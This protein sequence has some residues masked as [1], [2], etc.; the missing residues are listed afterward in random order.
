[1]KNKSSKSINTIIDFVTGK[2]IPEIGAEANRQ[3]VERYLVNE[4]G[5]SKK[6]IIVNA[7]INIIIEEDPYLSCLDLVVCVENKTK[8]MAIK[9]AAGSLGSRE[10]EILAGARLIDKKYQVPFAV[11]SDGK[12]ALMLDTVSGKKISEGLNSIFSSKEAKEKLKTLKLQRLPEERI[13]REKLIF[14]TYDVMNVNVNRKIP[15]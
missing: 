14:R 13:E 8:F 2:E 11:V 3:A 12:T 9:C 7:K 5:F 10:R 4:K 15:Q 6:D 1:M